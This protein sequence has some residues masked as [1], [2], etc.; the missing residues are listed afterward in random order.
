MLPEIT[1]EQLLSSSQEEEVFPSTLSSEDKKFIKEDKDKP[2]PKPEL[3]KFLE[4]NLYWQNI[5]SR[6]KLLVSLVSK[7]T[8]SKH[9]LITHLDEL[10]SHIYQHTETRSTAVESGAVKVLAKIMKTN[11]GETV[12]VNRTR[13]ILALLGN[14]PPTKGQG[15]K[16]LAIDG[17]GVR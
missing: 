7:S 1:R 10:F 11:E 17:G 2:H 14:N 6:T 16:I 5:E 4:T 9:N 8:S 15:I 3:S 12:V 13:E